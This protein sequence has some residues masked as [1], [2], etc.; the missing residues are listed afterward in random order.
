MVY[1][2]IVLGQTKLVGPSKIQEYFRFNSLCVILEISFARF[3]PGFCLFLTGSQLIWTFGYVGRVWSVVKFKALW[4]FLYCLVL[5]Q[6][7]LVTTINHKE[8]FSFMSFYE[9][10]DN[11][12]FTSRCLRAERHQLGFM[13]LVKKINLYSDFGLL[14]MKYYTVLWQSYILFTNICLCT[15]NL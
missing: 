11:C 14:W 7:Y 5:N 6:P 9:N 13:K 4:N 8:D 2:F 15:F 10:W 3:D 1:N 12:F